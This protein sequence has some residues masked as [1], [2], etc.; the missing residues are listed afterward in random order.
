MDTSKTICQNQKL[1]VRMLS[2]RKHF[3]K[4]CTHYYS[5]E[6]Y[7]IT[8]YFH[9]QICLLYFAI[10]SFRSQNILS[11][12]FFFICLERQIIITKYML[13]K[14]FHLFLEAGWQSCSFVDLIWWLIPGCRTLFLPFLHFRVLRPH[15]HRAP[16]PP[17]GGL[18]RGS[19]DSH[20]L[21]FPLSRSADPALS[22]KQ[23]GRTGGAD[24]LARQRRRAYGKLLGN[25]SCPSRAGHTEPHGQNAAATSL[26]RHCRHQQKRIYLIWKGQLWQTVK[27]GKV[28]DHNW[29]LWFA[30]Q[31][32]FRNSSELASP[33]ATCHQPQTID[34]VKGEHTCRQTAANLDFWKMWP[35]GRTFYCF[36]MF[37]DASWLYRQICKKKGIFEIAK[38]ILST[39]G[40]CWHLVVREKV[41]FSMF[42]CSSHADSVPHRQIDPVARRG[43]TTGLYLWL[44]GQGGLTC[45]RYHVLHTLNI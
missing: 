2:K 6:T 42:A 36:Y 13:R 34:H 15:L 3:A 10:G 21:S 37:R 39:L 22:V 19:Q 12:H 14:C 20:T 31:S 35:G 30:L 40:F 5:F 25:A 29:F 8:Q 26:F 41:E 45:V 44:G 38:K 28:L 32:S 16:R 9:S 43:G 27:K 24:Q 4:S 18:V 11:F 33:S 1:F 23:Q 17:A 7:Q